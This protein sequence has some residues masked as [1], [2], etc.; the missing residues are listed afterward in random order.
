[1][2]LFN[3]KLDDWKKYPADAPMRHCNLYR[4]YNDSYSSIGYI[5]HLSSGNDEAQYWTLDVWD[6]HDPVCQ[7]IIELHPHP[8]KKYSLEEL[9]QAKQDVDNLII[10]LN[11]LKAFI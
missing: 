4:K 8:R 7:M 11:K 6:A 10:K 9:D 5:R 1:M 3:Y 2:K